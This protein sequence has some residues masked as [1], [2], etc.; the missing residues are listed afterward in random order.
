MAYHEFTR[1]S[2]PRY[3]GL[4]SLGIFQLKSP[5]KIPKK[6]RKPRYH[7]RLGTQVVH[8]LYTYLLTLGLYL[9]SKVHVKK[10][11]EFFGTKHSIARR[12]QRHLR[13]LVFIS[14]GRGA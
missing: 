11:A 14:Y 13:A 4:R 5:Y 3:G 7:G 12:L 8:V 2:E 9:Y 10:M 6:D 1:A